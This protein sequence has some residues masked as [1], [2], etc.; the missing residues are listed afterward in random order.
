MKIYQGELTEP[1]IEAGLKAMTGRKGHF[2]L[3]AVS[4]A[5]R[6]SGA[7]N[8]HSGAEALVARELRLG[9]IRRITTGLYQ[10]IKE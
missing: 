2:T 5:L 4:L 6:E 1:Q 7:K 8:V 9:R 10:R 3:T